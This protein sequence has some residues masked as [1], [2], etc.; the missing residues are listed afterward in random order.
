MFLSLIDAR[1]YDI[2]LIENH[3]LKRAVTSFNYIFNLNLTS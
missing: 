2:T 1:S 3:S